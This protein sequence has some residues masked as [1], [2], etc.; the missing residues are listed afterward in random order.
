MYIIG[1]IRHLGLAR[2][3]NFLM[4]CS[5]LDFLR[6]LEERLKKSPVAIGRA[7]EAIATYMAL[8]AGMIGQQK[9]HSTSS[10]SYSAWFKSSRSECYSQKC[11]TRVFFCLGK[12]MYE[13]IGVQYTALCEN[14]KNEK[15]QH[16]NP[17]QQ[18]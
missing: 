9:R 8:R 17:T 13:V 12:K 7:S 5:T 6:I 18:G 3:T 2:G 10:Q 11:I 4:Y 1:D 15:N 14:E 16:P